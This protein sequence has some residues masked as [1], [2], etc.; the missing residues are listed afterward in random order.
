MPPE[1]APDESRGRTPVRGPALREGGALADTGADGGG[2]GLSAGGLG[3]GGELELLGFC[4]PEYAGIMIERIRNNWNRRQ[5]ATGVV[6]IRF[7]VQRDGRIT[8]VA[9]ETTSGH[10]ALDTSAERAVL[11]TRQLPYLPPAFAADSLTVYL[12]FEYR[13]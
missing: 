7:T 8:D 5:A 1:A 13:R 6:T 9:R 4:C 12:D 11:L 2:V 10:F 3:D